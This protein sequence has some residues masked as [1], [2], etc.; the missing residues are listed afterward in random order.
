MAASQKQKAFL[1]EIFKFYQVVK[2]LTYADDYFNN[3]MIQN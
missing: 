3:L 1:L 2:K